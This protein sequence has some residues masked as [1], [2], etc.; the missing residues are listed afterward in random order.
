MSS[1]QVRAEGGMG[2][3]ANAF[4]RRHIARCVNAVVKE[5]TV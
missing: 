3:S 2:A 5:A 1:E 4:G